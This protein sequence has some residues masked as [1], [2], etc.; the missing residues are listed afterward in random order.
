MCVL[1]FP[2]TPNLHRVCSSFHILETSL[3]Q[4]VFNLNLFSKTYRLCSS[5]TFLHQ[6]IVYYDYAHK[7]R[8]SQVHCEACS[9]E[10]TCNIQISQ[11]LCCWARHS[12]PSSAPRT[13]SGTASAPLR[14]H[15]LPCV[16]LWRNQVSSLLWWRFCAIHQ[17]CKMG[18]VRH[19]RVLNFSSL[20]L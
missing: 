16:A 20:I 11:G 14:T 10:Y 12:C 4:F 17:E 8:S 3:T 18:T 7:I 19:V 15:P 2:E 6:W 13:A 1:N 5:I 9:T